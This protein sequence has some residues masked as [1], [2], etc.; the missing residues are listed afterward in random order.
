MDDISLV[1][2]EPL[3]ETQDEP[4]ASVDQDVSALKQIDVALI[5]SK[6]ASKSSSSSSKKRTYDQVSKSKDQAEID[7]QSDQSLK[8]RKLSDDSMD[9]KVKPHEAKEVCAPVIVD[10]ISSFTEA[11]QT[12]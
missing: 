2:T 8:R 10:Q 1:A 7:S 4:T 12:L 9:S 5:D 3:K 6:P 11:F